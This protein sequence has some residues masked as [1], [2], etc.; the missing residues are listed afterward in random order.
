MKDTEPTVQL[1]LPATA[2]PT[3][4]QIIELPLPDGGGASKAV[5]EKANKPLRQNLWYALF[6]PQL[7]ELTDSQ[8]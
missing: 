1:P 7:L 4:A 8:Q 2:K 5:V 6:F 3:G